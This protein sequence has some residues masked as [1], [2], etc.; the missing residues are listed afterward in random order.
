MN[1]GRTAF[2]TAEAGDLRSDAGARATFA[3]A[4]GISSEWATVRQVHGGTVVRV[5]RPGDA[6][7]ADALFTTASGLPVVIFTADCFAVA[8]Y[9]DH[10]VGMAHAGWRGLSARVIRNL[11]EAMTDAGAE[12]THATIGPGI[13]PCCFEVGEE[14]ASVF[15]GHEAV[16]TW[17]TPSVDLA[18]V[19]RDEL[20][21]LE[22]WED[23]RCTH[24]GSGF[25]SHRRDRTT[26]RMAGVAWLP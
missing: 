11:R 20:D 8:L 18:G 14:V 22:W 2:S 3:A 4:L 13:G 25:F 7:M 5:H 10:G 17:G 21:G 26:K 19:V 1:Q 6:G 15:G 12:P 16:T 9:C 24:C 23:G